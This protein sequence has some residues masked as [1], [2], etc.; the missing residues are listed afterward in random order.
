MPY[1]LY[2]I[3]LKEDVWNDRKFAARNPNRRI[4]KPCVYV[5]STVR[6]PEERSEQHRNR[7]K[8]SRYAHQYHDGLHQ[9]LTSRQE[10]YATRPEAQ[11]A[12]AA[13][14][15]KLRKKG[16]ESGPTDFAYQL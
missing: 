14:A 3:R 7:Y 2:V 16:T 9:R 6:T 12:E 5:G 11:K 8:S 10:T 13:L 1:C 15:E 4:D